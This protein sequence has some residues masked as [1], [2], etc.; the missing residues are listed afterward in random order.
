MKPK[1]CHERT[2]GT[3]T[4]LSI[5]A[6][7]IVIFLSSHMS[8]FDRVLAASKVSFFFRLWKLWLDFGGHTHNL[9]QNFISWQA[10][11]R[12]SNV[13]SLYCVSH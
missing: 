5:I 7:Y 2:L 11:L 1:H 10:Y 6:N 12:C 9:E 4:Y 8:L 3:E 13:K